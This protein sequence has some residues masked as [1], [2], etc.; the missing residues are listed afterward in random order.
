[1]VFQTLASTGPFSV[2]RSIIT[3]NSVL[4]PACGKT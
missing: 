4:R 2:G 1:M 3:I